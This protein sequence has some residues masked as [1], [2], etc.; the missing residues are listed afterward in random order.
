MSLCARYRFTAAA[1]DREAPR[2]R[3]LPVWLTLLQANLILQSQ[4]VKYF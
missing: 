4:S 1:E 3:V 2:Q